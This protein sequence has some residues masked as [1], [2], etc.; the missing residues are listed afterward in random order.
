[1]EKTK[2]LKWEFTEA[3]EWQGEADE[4]VHK[5]AFERGVEIARMVKAEG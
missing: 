1:M 4:E 3:L 2:K 5:L